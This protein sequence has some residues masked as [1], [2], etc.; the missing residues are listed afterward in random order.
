MHHSAEAHFNPDN[1]YAFVLTSPA[2]K[3]LLSENLNGYVGALSKSYSN[4]GNYFNEVVDVA[5]L[6]LTPQAAGAL[7]QSRAFSTVFQEL[8]ENLHNIQIGK[9]KALPGKLE[10]VLQ[11][12]VETYKKN[13]KP[14]PVTG[15]KL[16]MRVEY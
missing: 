5:E 1:A 12:Y 15:K 14:D 11:P 9:Y 7:T 13:M 4:A 10:S 3:G 6:G 16:L 2:D 8:I